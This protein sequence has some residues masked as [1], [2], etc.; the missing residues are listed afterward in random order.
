M[1]QKPVQGFYSRV[2]PFITHANYPVLSIKSHIES[3]T[4]ILNT[5]FGPHP[6]ILI[7]P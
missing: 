2:A 7:H 1:I 3:L 6:M 4:L 5:K